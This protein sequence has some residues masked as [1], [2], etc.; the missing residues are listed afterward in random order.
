MNTLL[1]DL[2]YA[3]RMLTKNPGFAIAAILTIAFGIGINT[4]LF[5][6]V[7]AFLF[8]PLPVK[9]PHEL[10]VLGT[11]DNHMVF[12]HGISYPDYLD[13][14]KRA[15]VF[16][17]LAL[18]SLTPVSM[19]DDRQAERVWV[20]AVTANYFSL[21][22]VNPLHGRVL[23]IDDDRARGAS[24]VIVLSYTLWQRRFGADPS[25]VGR[26]IKLNG[27]P[28]TVVGV[29]PESF[30]GTE[31]LLDVEAYVPLMA[32]VDVGAQSSTQLEDRDAHNFR[33][34]ARLAQGTTV[35]Q[36]R[37]AVST[38]AANLSDQYPATNKDVNVILVP[39]T[40]SRPEISTGHL[41]KPAA[42]I[43]MF[44]VGLVLLIACANVANLL[45]VRGIARG[46]EIALRSALG[47]SRSRIIR[48]LL[49]ESSLIAI[50][51]AAAGLALAFWTSQFLSDV[52]KSYPSDLRLRADLSIDWRVFVFTLGMALFAG[53]VAGLIPALRGSRPHLVEM[54]KEGGRSSGEG[55][56]R[57]KLRNLLVIAQVSV[58]LML[59]V[60]AGLFFKSLNNA[61]NV[62]LG[63]R[64]NNMVLMS[65][66]P[67]LQG[68]DASRRL[69]YYQQAT[70][71][72]RALP[73]VESASWATY[74][75]FSGYGVSFNSVF[76]E[77]AEPVEEGKAPTVMN[78]S[79][80]TA[81]F[82]TIGMAIID[83]RAFT[84]EDNASSRQVA[85]INE[86]M[87]KE[88][89]PGEN[90]LGRKFR[91]DRKDAQP[92]EVVGVSRTS[93]YALLWEDPQPFFYLPIKQ[94]NPGA[95]VLHVRS[96]SDMAAIVTAVRGELR[97]LDAEMPIFDVKSIEGHL[98]Y[99]NA[100][101][102]SRMGAFFT[103]AFGI[104]GLALA[105]IGIYGVI[106]YSVTQRTQEIGI[107]MALGASR[108]EVL[109][110]ILGHGVIVIAIGVAI[111]C[112]GALALTSP[113]SYML[114]GVSATDP[115]IFAT[116]A[117]LLALVALLA[118]WIPARRATKVDPMVALRYE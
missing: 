9:N 43:F 49:T 110:M 3:V 104:V 86:A 101:L 11:Q 16:A 32:M 103:G 66:D 116:V 65:V 68:Y 33:T 12:P 14:K 13:Y 76:V 87:A 10:V 97:A 25:V 55:S 85:I 40:E 38:I 90:P 74:V 72:V 84:E 7:N 106:S 108:T 31:S 93:K 113:L 5:S 58:S 70:D 82:D 42:G 94:N 98:Q 63:F 15:D 95:A 59:L 117:L 44:L 47:A 8:R 92:F 1:Q 19:S 62:D 57:H 29:S 83:G 30:P 89:W 102:P 23:T 81:Y 107:R 71:R 61:H 46:K 77:G 24:P 2:R 34:I 100:Y 52:L 88:L 50:L 37:A 109:K 118:C 73:G 112:I 53:I 99:G 39:E 27:H 115:I 114:M 36:A 111:G 17:D 41:F 75:N 80:D 91:T 105:T 18:K 4:A 67:G 96:K 20:E 78:M 28:F 45:L 79:A 22:G 6:I 69:Q 64:A 35:E 54:I 21:L 60:C 26:S 56:G 48:Q 51:G